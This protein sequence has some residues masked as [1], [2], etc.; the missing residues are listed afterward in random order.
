MAASSWNNV[1][2]SEI[3]EFRN[4]INYNKTNFGKGI[5]VV[6]VKDFQDRSFPIYDNLEEINPDGVVREESLLR[7]GDVLFVRS[8]GNRELIGRSLFVRDLPDYA[9]THSAFT[10]RVR[11]TSPEAN[12]RFLA[13][14]FRSRLIRDVL[15]AQGNGANI[16]NLNQDILSRLRVPLPDRRTQARVASILSA[17]DDLIENNS[18]RIAILEKMARLIYEEWFVRFRFPGRKE[19]RMVESELGLVPKGWQVSPCSS[20]AEF[21]NGYAFKP[22]DWSAHGVP[23]IKI[24][25][26][27]DGVTQ[28]TPRLEGTI[29]SRYKI[30]D[31]DL[32]FSWSADLDVYLWNGGRGWL[33]Q[34][35]FQVQPTSA[36]KCFMFHALRQVMPEFRSKSAGTTMRHIKRSA[37]DEVRLLVPPS[38][39]HE[40][41]DAVAAPMDALVLQLERK[42]RNLRMT[43]DLLLPKLISGEL[44]VSELSDSMADIA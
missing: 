9:V 17:Y 15:S 27:K 30:H 23:I 33:N 19:V 6:G 34:H 11:P 8:N 26:L 32:L 12:P 1:G 20:V 16:S 14:L 31:G 39:L 10:I 44:D 25:E 29:A 3:A 28:Q 35:L 21:I 5:R 2:L 36:S 40:S 38:H 13:Y 24:K 42:N 22:S 7:N 41:F 37:L 4:G 18:R 43:R